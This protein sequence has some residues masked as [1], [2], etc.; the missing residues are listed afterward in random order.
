MQA[1]ADHGFHI[2]PDPGVLILRGDDAGEFLNGQITNDVAAL[3]DGDSKYALL[4]TPKGKLRAELTVVRD[5]DE[6]MVVCPAGQLPLIRKMIDTYRIGFFFSVE[7]ATGE[8]SLVRILHGAAP[9]A[10][11][12]PVVEIDSPLGVDLLVER[13]QQPMLIDELTRAG[14]AELGEDDLARAR[15]EALV[16]AFGAELNEDTFPAEA[17]LE[18]RAVSFEKGCYVGQETVARMHYKGK[19]NRHLRQLVAERPLP[20]GAAVTAADGRELGVIGTSVT[21]EDGGALALAILRR[22]GEPG[23]T[24]DVEGI[25]ATIVQS[26]EENP[27]A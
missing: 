19:P 7:D 5:G 21:T 9:E 2:A 20:A 18:A 6:T 17:A 23:S 27:A 11:A 3:A 4:L 1:S 25:P 13:S 26:V 10:L 15:V 12:T 8:W 24:V 14:L 16:P 22:E